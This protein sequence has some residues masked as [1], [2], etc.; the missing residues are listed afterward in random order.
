M[1]AR[2]RLRICMIGNPESVHVINRASFLRKRGHEV[3]VLDPLRAAAASPA[4]GAMRWL[5]GVPKLRVLVQVIRLH[6]VV[7]AIQADIVHV[8]YVFGIRAWMA[9]LAAP[10]PLVASAWGSDLLWPEALGASKR[11]RWLTME[12]LRNADLVT[13]ESSFL[14]ETL[15]RR[16]GIPVPPLEN[17]W[18][19]DLEIF[20]VTD[21]GD[22][23]QQLAIPED[24]A[25]LFCP[26][27]LKPLYNA[28]V[29]IEA[30]PAI[31]RYHPSVRLLLSTYAAEAAYRTELEASVERLGL[32][33]HVLFLPPI[34]SD[35]MPAYYSLADLVVT[36]PPSDGVPRSL[37]EAMACGVP[38]IMAD[39]PNYEGLAEHGKNAWLID[40]TPDAVA[41]SVVTLLGDGEA[42]S[43]IVQ[44]G[45]ETVRKIADSRKQAE[46]MEAAYMNLLDRAVS[47]P[48]LAWR[49]RFLWVLL[50]SLAFSR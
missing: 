38:S 28:D 31:K 35:K 34:E 37:F 15:R 47:R 21:P 24:A 29:I 9:A 41:E 7:R 27:P 14:A 49:L 25:V 3:E 50:L 6:A 23:R 33:D 42:Y 4:G 40:I 13:V 48:R 5:T 32:A 16:G 22:L 45:A 20:R 11:Q 26:K 46:T 44:N 18:G 1:S 30:L 39:L 2:R 43:R 12:L 36:I 17:N 8:H 19:I 10:R